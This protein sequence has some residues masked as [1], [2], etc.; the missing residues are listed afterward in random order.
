MNWHWFGGD[1]FF[2]EE[3]LDEL[4]KISKEFYEKCLTEN[5]KDDTIDA[6][7]EEYL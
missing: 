6:E 5:V 2:T 7:R 3:Q 4:D 1:Y